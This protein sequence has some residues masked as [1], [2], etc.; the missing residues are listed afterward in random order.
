M[1]TVAD[2]AGI[3]P[4]KQLIVF[5][6]DGFVR[7]H[8]GLLEFVVVQDPVEV[9]DAQ[10]IKKLF[11]KDLIAEDDRCIIRRKDVRGSC[12]R[13]L[14]SP[15][16]HLQTG[17]RSCVHLKSHGPVATERFR[18]F[19]LSAELISQFFRYRDPSPVAAILHLE[20]AQFRSHAFNTIL[21][22]VLAPENARSPRDQGNSCRSKG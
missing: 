7:R 6:C 1:S 22:P 15:N 14:R 11:C 21:T 13:H 10:S 12:L 20:V 17:Y 5:S 16:P 9:L 19:R 18:Q 3:D 2:L 8:V 4:R